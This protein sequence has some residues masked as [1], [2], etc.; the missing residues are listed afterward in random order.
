MNI[1]YKASIRNLNAEDDSQVPE[2]RKFINAPTLVVVS[3]Q[4]Y[5]TRA[6]VAE[7]LSPMR[8]RNYEIKKLEGCGQWIQLE[9]KDQFSEILVQFAERNGRACIFKASID[10]LDIIACIVRPTRR[11][12]CEAAFS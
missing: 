4:D 9:K 1:R 11:V 2:E 3:D 5:I 12:G 7:Q 6:E 8:L 10:A